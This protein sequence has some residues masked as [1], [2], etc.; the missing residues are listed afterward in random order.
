[1]LL[2]YNGQYGNIFELMGRGVG[3]VVRLV[4]KFFIFLLGTS[5]FDTG[6]MG[7]PQ[8][9]TETE[10]SL[11]EI[12]WEMPDS[13]IMQAIFEAFGLVLV[14]AIVIALIYMVRTYIKNFNRTKKLGND[15]IEYIVPNEDTQHVNKMSAN[16]KKNAPRDTRSVRRMYK[17]RVLKGTGGKPP[18]PSA[19][20]SSLTLQNITDNEE[21][22]E[23]ITAVYEKARYSEERITP[24]EAS[25]FKD[26]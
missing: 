16:D 6:S 15:Y 25:V 18:E 17:K 3:L 10:E 22:A 19:P 11:E 24:E 26:I 12:D 8:N 2:F 14:I 9:D 5:G 23:K 20:P 13:P 7:M 4:V 21:L 1:M